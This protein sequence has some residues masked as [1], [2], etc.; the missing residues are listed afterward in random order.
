[1]HLSDARDDKIQEEDCHVAKKKR[2]STLRRRV[3]SPGPSPY[4]GEG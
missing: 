3:V 4:Q 2:P 1:M